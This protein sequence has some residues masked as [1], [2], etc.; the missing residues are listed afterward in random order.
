MLDRTPSE[1]TPAPGTSH[2]VIYQGSAP[3]SDL[4]DYVTVDLRL[5]RNAEEPDDGS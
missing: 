1:G 5:W 4:S 2:Q 3:E